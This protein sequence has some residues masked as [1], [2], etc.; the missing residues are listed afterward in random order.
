MYIYVCMQHRTPDSRR[1]KKIVY[2][3]P[4]LPLL[5]LAGSVL[6]CCNMSYFRCCLDVVA[7]VFVAGSAICNSENIHPSEPPSK[8]LFPILRCLLFVACF[9]FL[10]FTCFFLLFFVQ[11]CLPW[12]VKTGFE[13]GSSRLSCSCGPSFIIV[14]FVPC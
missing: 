1:R 8:S 14:V 12:R 4:T 10:F 9:C 6:W 3:L 13:L 7:V 5:L 2:M 11:P